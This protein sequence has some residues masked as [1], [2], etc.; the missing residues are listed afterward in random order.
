MK[1]EPLR[2]HKVLLILQKRTH[3]N[4]IHLE[5]HSIVIRAI[6]ART[7]ETK[8]PSSRAAP[9][10]RSVVQVQA[11]P[12]TPLAVVSAHSSAPGMF[13]Q[14]LCTTLTNNV[15]YCYAIKINH[16]CY[17]FLFFKQQNN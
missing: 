10:H 12:V 1:I 7:T 16:N 9:L 5:H 13:K 17:C 14:V 2:M 8:A 11:V 15:L 3:L 6:T 4:V